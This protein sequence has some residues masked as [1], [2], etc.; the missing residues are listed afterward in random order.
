M[1]NSLISSFNAGEISPYLD[2]RSNL[3]KYRNGCRVLENFLIT[4]YGPANRRPGFNYRGL[5]KNESRVRLIGLNLS[6][7]SQ[8]ILELG[9]GYMRFWDNGEIIA[10]PGGNP[11]EPVPVNDQNE[12]ITPPPT[13]HP[14]QENEL[15]QVKVCQVNNVV[16]MTHP[17]HT[18]MRLSKYANTDWTIGPVPWSWPP[19]LDQNLGPISV[20]PSGIT[21]SIT[22][23]SSPDPLWSDNDV[24]SFFQINYTTGSGVLTE[25]IP[26]NSAS[27]LEILGKWSLA[28]FGTWDGTLY[29]ESSVDGGITWEVRRTY[30]SRNDFNAASNG[31]EPTTTLFRF[32]GVATTEDN[33]RVQLSATDPTEQGFIKIDSVNGTPLNGLYSSIS[34]TVYSDLGNSGVSTTQWRKGA[35]SATQGYPNAVVLH[36]SRV[37]FA[38]T[39]NNPNQLWASESS[40]FENFRLAALDASSWSFSL[41]TASGGRVQWLVSKNAL[42]IGTTLEEWSLTPPDAAV[43]ITSTNVSANVQSSYGSTSLPAIVVNDTILYF[44]RMGRKVRELIYTYASESWVSNDVTALAEHVTRTGLVED[45]WQRVPDA[46]LW[47]IRNDG[48]LVSMTYERQQEVIGFARHLTDG[49]FESVATING[50][51]AE[52]EVWVSI[53]R[54]GQGKRFIERLRIGSRDATE[55]GDKSNWFFLDAATQILPTYTE[56]IPDTFVTVQNIEHLNG[57]RLSFWC[58]KWNTATQTITYGTTESVV[59]PETGEPSVVKDGEVTLQEPVA[60]LIYGL[61]F[62][63]TISPMQ[64]VAD[65]N[66]GTS[67]GRKMRI[68]R[69]NVKIFE[70]FGGEYSTDKV[71]WNPMQGRTMTEDMDDSPAIINGFTRM[72]VAS[73][74]ADGVDIYIRQRLPVPLTISAIV[75]SWEAGESVS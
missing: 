55:T 33:A 40:N 59:D 71:N 29:L 13:Q 61:P 37:I 65:L 41:A 26:V 8:I 75:P 70:S 32:T 68:P 31:E 28:T 11:V 54:P 47:A 69:M 60:A 17:N 53:K 22:V 38:G 27:T 35:F 52:D 44:Q 10:Y 24:G 14:Y 12:V 19:M 20:N 49:E 51:D 57:K 46:I 66:D 72:S 62:T 9:V 23:S 18:P 16:Y 45:A 56:G 4:P 15:R 74:W 42:L 3:P 5:S 73:N 30:V 34:A 6:D 58:G 63:S 64:V 48:V 7:A 2:A 50:E 36:E 25:D 67:Q 21:G 39:K 1:I 43:G